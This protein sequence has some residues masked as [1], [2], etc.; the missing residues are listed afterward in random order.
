MWGSISKSDDIHWC[1]MFD[2]CW[3]IRLSWRNMRDQYS[4]TCLTHVFPSD[5]HWRYPYTLAHQAC[6]GS[7]LQWSSTFLSRISFVHEGGDRG[8]R[9]N[10][11]G[12]GEKVLRCGAEIIEFS[13][14]GQCWFHAIFDAIFDSLMW[15]GHC[16]PLQDL[17]QWGGFQR[18][19]Q[20]IE[21]LVKI[22]SLVWST[23]K[24]GVCGSSAKSFTPV[25]E[26][27]FGF[28]SLTWSFLV[29]PFGALV[30]SHSM[31][32]MP[33]PNKSKKSINL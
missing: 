4:S 24:N 26:S 6:D 17:N 12:W 30:L 9:T 31:I 7:Q 10:D 25:L 33:W 3:G 5:F 2:A 18:E 27:R 23:E 20:K 1:L 22:K 21:G 28:Q 15:S 8:L 13:S 14:L 11:Q 19:H 32:F 29:G 16:W